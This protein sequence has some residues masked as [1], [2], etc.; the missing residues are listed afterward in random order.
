M[1]LARLS[2]QINVIVNAYNEYG[3]LRFLDR[4]K[5]RFYFKLKQVDFSRVTLNNIEECVDNKE[6][7]TMYSATTYHG[8]ESS[9]NKIS[10]IDSKIFEGAFIDYGSGKGL[11]LYTAYKM[12]F[13]KVIGV[14]FMKELHD[15]A[16]NNLSKLLKN[17]K[18]ITINK[19]AVEVPPP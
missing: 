3:L 15:I 10:K 18:I 7:G 14:E 16:N 8:L 4:I 9:I 13:N 1:N 17:R 2:R 5:I 11:T 19:D 12:K 6:F